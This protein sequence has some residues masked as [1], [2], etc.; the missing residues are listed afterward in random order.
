MSEKRVFDGADSPAARYRLGVMHSI[1]F[2][3]D[4]PQLRQI[5]STVLADAHHAV[6]TAGDGFQAL[7][8][9]SANHVDLLITDIKMPGMSGLQLGQQAKLLHPKLHVMYISG[10]PASPSYGV[11]LYKPVRPAE[12][13]A[14]VRRKLAMAR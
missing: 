12:L 11:V 5:V 8:I 1:L 10:Y 4:D 2:V 6:M 3:D 7:R 14:E 13:T 9:L